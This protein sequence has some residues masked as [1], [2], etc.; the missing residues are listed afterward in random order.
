MD[1]WRYWGDKVVTMKLFVEG[2]GDA[3]TLRTA[4]RRG[5]SEFLKKSGLE[6]MPRVV[7]CGSRYDAYKAFSTAM[8]QNESAMLLV[9]SEAP[10]SPACQ[11]GDPK[12][13]EPWKHLHDRL[14]DQWKEPQ[15]AKDED[16]HFMVQ[17][18]EAWLLAD[19]DILATYF[20]QDFKAKQLPA[21]TRPIESIAKDEICES[22]AN[23]TKKLKT[24]K[25]Y[26][27]GKHSFALLEKIDPSSVADASPWGKRFI[28]GIKNRMD[29]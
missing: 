9:D 12:T 15:N 1:P 16:C 22:L 2:G 20:G 28:D 27:K 26:D 24:K 3:K 5:F 14:G 23:A 18:M 21:Q 4:C 17:C 29:S 6:H 7:A 10:V 8:A 19:R 25:P 13:W 11:N